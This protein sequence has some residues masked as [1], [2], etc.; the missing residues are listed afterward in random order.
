MRH[1]SV[2]SVESH[3]AR[4]GQPVVA[5]ASCYCGDLQEGE[6]VLRPLRAFGSPL[7]DGMQ[8]M[9]YTGMQGLFGPSFPWNNRNY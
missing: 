3:G 6:R 2:R 1:T 8:A 5:L 9:P 4:D 7:M